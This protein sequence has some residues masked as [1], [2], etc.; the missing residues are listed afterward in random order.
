MKLADLA[1][2][3]EATVFSLEAVSSATRKKLMVMGILPQTAI[4]KVRVAPMGD[5]IQVR[6]RGVDV[7]IR[8]SLAEC[9]EVTPK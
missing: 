9:I 4:T 2:G 3:A 5:P 1:S 7:A 6:V 8:K